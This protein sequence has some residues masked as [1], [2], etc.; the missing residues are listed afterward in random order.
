[1]NLVY[2]TNLSKL[3][4]PIF[5]EWSSTNIRQLSQP[6]S[7]FCFRYEPESSLNDRKR[8]R[9]EDKEIH[10]AQK[11][12]HSPVVFSRFSYFSFLP[13]EMVLCIFS[14]LDLTSLSCVAQVS[15][16]FNKLAN[17]EKL[18]L[19]RYIRLWKNNP[20][21]D[22]Y[23]QVRKISWKRLYFMRK[24]T[25]LFYFSL[26]EHWVPRDAYTFHSWG[27]LLHNE[28]LNYV[29]ANPAKAEWL[30]ILAF[31]EYESS[32]SIAPEVRVI[33]D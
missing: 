4:N 21:L 14:F 32:L 26:R 17:H 25:E 18:W 31:Q 27:D 33:F 24:K 16:S 29:T 7:G 5:C 23:F 28:A 22:P 3:K 10:L 20:E 6:T 15:V 8:K 11:R 1:M 19:D 9:Q 30:F 12:V 13:E 2:S